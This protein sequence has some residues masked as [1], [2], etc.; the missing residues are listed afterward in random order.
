MLFVSCKTP[1]TAS[2]HP[3]KINIASPAQIMPKETIVTPARTLL[4]N[5]NKMPANIQLGAQVA[6]EAN[7]AQSEIITVQS[8]M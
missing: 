8:D 3:K 4:S 6:T 2:L 5:M 1:F 7:I